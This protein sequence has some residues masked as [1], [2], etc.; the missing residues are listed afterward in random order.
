MDAESLSSSEGLKPAAA[1]DPGAS[2]TSELDYQAFGFSGIPPSP[3]KNSFPRWN[4]DGFEQGYDSDGEILLSKD[5]LFESN[6]DEGVLPSREEGPFNQA[7]IP[8]AVGGDQRLDGGAVY[9]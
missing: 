5:G 6:D 4:E 7:T 1:D 2:N 9:P 8:E 3:P